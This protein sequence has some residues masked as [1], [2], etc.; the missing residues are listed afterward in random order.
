MI[1]YEMKTVTGLTPVL[2][3]GHCLLTGSDYTRLQI[4]KNLIYCILKGTTKTDTHV[5]I[6]TPCKSIRDWFEGY[7]DEPGRVSY[8]VDSVDWVLNSIESTPSDKGSVWIFVDPDSDQQ[9]DVDIY[10]KL[11]RILRATKNT[12]TQLVWITLCDEFAH[13]ILNP[14]AFD[15]RMVCACNSNESKY[16]WGD[17]TASELSDSE[18]LTK[19]ELGDNLV[20]VDTSIVKIDRK[21]IEYSVAKDT[22]DFLGEI[23]VTLCGYVA[24]LAAIFLFVWWVV[25]SVPVFSTHTHSEECYDS[26]VRV[27]GKV[28]N[29]IV[30]TE[31]P[32]PSILDLLMMLKQEESNE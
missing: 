23:I 14:N 24:C 19:S 30:L 12:D 31:H 18:V 4:A 32:L 9:L 10:K 26:G 16:Y 5:N 1:T 7:F 15:T 11:D 3:K 27:C 13:G 29:E 6:I 21:D 17:I 2:G 25:S 22:D 8:I 28:D 20:S